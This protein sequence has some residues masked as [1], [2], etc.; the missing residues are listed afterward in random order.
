MGLRSSISNLESLLT[1]KTKLQRSVF[2]FY[3]RLV[4]AF[5]R[6]CRPARWFSGNALFC[7][8]YPQHEGAYLSI[9]AAVKGSQ[10]EKRL[11][12][13]FIARFFKHFHKLQ[14]NA[15]DSMLD[16]CEDEDSLV[17]DM[18]TGFVCTTVK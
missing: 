1:R 13:S 18:L 14:D 3:R 7:A 8:P 4:V 6:G 5:S 10:G 17:R 11:A 12:G 2:S 15:I 9:L 16:L